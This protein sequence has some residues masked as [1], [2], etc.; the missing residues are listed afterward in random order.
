MREFLETVNKIVRPPTAAREIPGI[1]IRTREEMTAL[2]NERT[3]VDFG[4][5]GDQFMAAHDA[6][7][8]DNS[9]PIVHHDT[10]L[11]GLSPAQE[12]EQK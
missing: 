10:I 12:V 5:T 2:L 9:D 11:A 7:E 4:M 8:L 1:Q 6:G 3:L